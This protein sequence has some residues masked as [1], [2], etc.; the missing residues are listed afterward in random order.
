LPEHW[1]KT[2]SKSA[3]C[4]FRATAWQLNGLDN[5]LWLASTANLFLDFVEEEPE[6]N[7]D[8]R[9]I[10]FRDQRR[11]W[12]YQSEPKITLLDSYRPDQ[13]ILEFSHQSLPASPENMLYGPG[14]SLT[15]ALA[16]AT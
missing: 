8:N 9:M 11:D 15:C 1:Q 3:L 14:H 10:I 5:Y 7:P 2:V 4:C 6:L 16:M 12:P 13:N